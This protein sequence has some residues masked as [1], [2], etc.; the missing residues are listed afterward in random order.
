MKT[1]KIITLVVF[2][3]LVGISSMEAQ[4]VQNRSQANKVAMENLTEAQ[5]LM[6]QQQ[7]ELIK[8]NRETFKASLSAEQLAILENA[9]LTKQQRRTALIAS[10]TKGQQQLL[11]QQKMNMQMVRQQFKSTLTDD[12]LQQI[13][14]RLR[15]YKNIQDGKELMGRVKDRRHRQHN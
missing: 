6:L 3:L 5:K 9:A 12:Q 15:G 11:Q 8:H 4:Q 13:R 10:F 7:R 1:I 14:M 2:G